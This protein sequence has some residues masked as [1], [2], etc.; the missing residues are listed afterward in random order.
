MQ[1]MEVSSSMDGVQLAEWSSFEGYPFSS[2]IQIHNGRPQVHAS[3][4]LT[5][6]CPGFYT[7]ENLESVKGVLEDYSKTIYDYN[8]SM[9]RTTRES[10]GASNWVETGDI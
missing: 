4:Q 1:P 2:W 7:A 10:L 6:D 9:I 3:F 5:G 8:M